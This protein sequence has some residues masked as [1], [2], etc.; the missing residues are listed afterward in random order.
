MWRRSLAL[1]ETDSAGVDPVVLGVIWQKLVT[2]VDEVAQTFLRTCFST[3]VREN[4]DF[5]CAIFDLEG[6]LLAQST[7]SIPSF[8]GTMPVT[9][10]AMLDKFPPHTMAPGD[11]VISNNP[12]LGPGHL[13]DITMCCPVFRGGRLVAY[14]GSISHSVDIGGAPS[15]ASRDVLEEGL[16][17]PVLKIVEGGRENGAVIDFIA[18]N[19]RVPKDTLGDLRAQFGAYGVG[20]RKVGELLGENRLEDLQS[21]AREIMSR[22]ERAM[23]RRIAEIPD[24]RWSGEAVADG[25]DSP[26]TIRGSVEVAGSDIYIDYHGTAPQFDRPVNSVL[27]FTR[28]YTAYAVKCALDPTLPNN[29]GCFRPVHVEAPAGSILNPEPPAPVWARH[30][31]GHYLPFVV[32]AALSRAIPDRVCAESGSPLWSVYFKGKD[33][34]GKRF[35]TIFFMNGGHGAR[36]GKDGPNC[37]SFPS[38]VSNTPIEIVENSIPV[39]VRE[40]E[41]VSGSGGPGK[42]RGGCGQQISFEVLAEEPLT[43]TIRHERVKN[44]PRGMLGGRPG[45]PGL[46]LVDGRAIPPKTQMQLSKGDVVTFRTPGGGGFLPPED[47]DPGAVAADLRSGLVLPETATPAGSAMAEKEMA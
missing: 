21:V 4:Y 32:F 10:R 24:G 46:E 11:V 34:R 18:E 15:H 43:M 40:K 45:M 19:V 14:M 29:D 36:P 22:S 12:W 28:A 3:V 7:Y 1:T 42:F 38:N 5:A 44:P 2:L 37:L 31:T 9:L 26:L 33:Y 41:L 35:V 20:V 30:L 6:R 23:R 25:Y 47:R 13:N 39:L 17:I 16:C 8:I 27:N